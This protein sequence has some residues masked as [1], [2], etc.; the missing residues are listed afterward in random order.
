[1][2]LDEFLTHLK[3]LDAEINRQTSMWGESVKNRF[4]RTKELFGKLEGV[5]PEW[6]FFI[7]QT[8]IGTKE[9]ILAV[10]SDLEEAL[11][12]EDSVLL[13]DTLLYGLQADVQKYL[14]VISGAMEDE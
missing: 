2:D 5:L 10:L 7:E 14:T 11:R 3:E 13:A 12:T 6:F 4:A 1:M 9:E 8:E